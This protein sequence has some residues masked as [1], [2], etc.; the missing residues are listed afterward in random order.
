MLI[1]PHDGKSGQIR[2]LLQEHDLLARTSRYYLGLDKL[3][4]AVNER[5]E[6][7]ILPQSI[8]ARESLERAEQVGNDGKCVPFDLI[9]EYGRFP[10]E[11]A[12][13]V[14][15]FRVGT[16]VELAI[17]GLGHV[18]KVAGLFQVV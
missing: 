13:D 4:I 12:L 5:G 7:I 17:D 15:A 16:D 18:K 9:E 6:K 2:L 1:P 11:L 3:V 14:S 10:S 8:D